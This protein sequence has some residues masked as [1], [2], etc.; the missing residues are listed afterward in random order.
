MNAAEG[1]DTTHSGLG[2]TETP[3]QGDASLTLGFKIK[4]PWGFRIGFD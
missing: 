1:S 3:T 2:N 4:P